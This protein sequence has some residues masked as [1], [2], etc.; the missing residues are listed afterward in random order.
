MNVSDGKVLFLKRSSL[1]DFCP[2]Q[3]CFPGGHVEDDESF[4]E[5]ALRECREETGLNLSEQG[6]PIKLGMYEN[7][8]AICFYFQVFVYSMGSECGVLTLD[9]NEH[10][11]YVWMT[12]KEAILKLD[13]MLN[14]GDQMENMFF[15][16]G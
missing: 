3:W 14:L 5:A 1:C 12:P 10:Q 8:K 13:L 16:I 11:H 4:D 7:K 6:T 9:M 2:G 15:N